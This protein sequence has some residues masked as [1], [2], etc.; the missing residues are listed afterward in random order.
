M[1]SNPDSTPSGESPYDVLGL[2]PGASEDEIEDA[3][4][5]LS[6]MFAPGA[7]AESRQQ[8]A[9]RQRSRL[10][11]AY[12]EL[13]DPDR[14]QALDS[15]LGVSRVASAAPVV[16]PLSAMADLPTAPKVDAATIEETAPVVDTYSAEEIAPVAAQPTPAEIVSELETDAATIEETAPVS[17]EEYA[18]SLARDDETQI[19]QPEQEAAPSTVKFAPST[20]PAPQV[21][22]AAPQTPAPVS[23]PEPE[24]FDDEDLED[25]TDLEEDEPAPYQQA[26]ARFTP[27]PRQKVTSKPA[28]TNK[29]EGG[30]N[31]PSRQ[32]AAQITAAQTAQAARVAAPPPPT[33]RRTPAPAAPT[34]QRP[35]QPGVVRRTTPGP[36]GGVVSTPAP[37]RRTPAPPPAPRK[38]KKNNSMLPYQI[39]TGVVALVLILGTVA[40]YIGSSTSTVGSV[41]PTVSAASYVAAG[42]SALAGGNGTGALNNYSQAL[43]IDP[44]NQDA[45]LG[46]A[47]YYI[48]VDQPDLARNYITQILNVNSQTQEAQEALSLLTDLGASG[49]P[50]SAPALS[51]VTTSAALSSPAVATPASVI[52]NTAPLTTSGTVA[53]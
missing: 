30:V 1:S 53:P 24:V 14:K 3:Y 48:T 37:A 22:L 39:L 26:P 7:V 5:D 52:S 31:L 23:V 50:T 9:R 16:E 51:P 44:N 8:W 17:P 20:T 43:T 42:D 18:Q 13:M 41:A 38:R 4:S 49:S 25:L 19:L 40:G 46:L 2:A 21:Q 15:R 45:M 11:A 6:K 12:A 36:Q 34:A 47:R 33:T 29:S 10:A 27:S 28:I 35:T 32:K